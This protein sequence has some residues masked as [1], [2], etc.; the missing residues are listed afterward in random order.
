MEPKMKKY[1][2]LIAGVLL[3]VA[4]LGFSVNAAYMKAPASPASIISTSIHATKETKEIVK[5]IEK[6]YDI[7]AEAAYKFDISKFPTVFINDPRF[8]VD[9]Y[10][11]D[12]V[13]QLTNQP[14]LESAGWLDYKEAYYS[15]RIN[16]TLKEEALK[17]KAKAEKRQL[18]EKEK[19]SL[20]DPWGRTAPA[21]AQSSTRRIPL[22]FVSI[23][24]KDDI[25]VVVINDGPYTAELTLVLVK[26]KWYI[27]AWKGISINV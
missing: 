2:Y 19:E 4:I 1:I 10:T 9:T 3:I 14:K 7:E 21:R 23:D 6:A 12:V 27:A 13:R 24:V 16:A 22:K 18:T 20:S 17:E 5:T 25:A 26:G 11:L 8:N 15:W